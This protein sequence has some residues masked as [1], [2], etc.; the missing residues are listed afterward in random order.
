MSVSSIIDLLDSSDSS[1]V[2]SVH[3]GDESDT[4]AESDYLAPADIVTQVDDS[5]LI[6][7]VISGVDSWSDF[8]R[9][10][11]TKSALNDPYDPD[12][13]QRLEDTNKIGVFEDRDGKFRNNPAIN[14]NFVEM[15]E[16]DENM[17]M[18]M[19]ES[20]RETQD[21]WKK[22]FNKANVMPC[23]IHDYV[24]LTGDSDD[25]EDT[26]ED[27][28]EVAMSGLAEAFSKVSSLDAASVKVPKIKEK[29]KEWYELVPI[30]KLRYVIKKVQGN[31][32]E[33]SP[34]KCKKS[35]KSPKEAHKSSEDLGSVLQESQHETLCEKLLETPMCD[36]GECRFVFDDVKEEQ[37]HVRRCHKRLEKVD[38][39]EEDEL[40]TMQA[41][42]KIRL[43]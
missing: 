36:G 10:K 43:E 5:C 12:Y 34:K 38:E 16:S 25:D 37:E 3:S 14:E 19:T 41:S 8:F 32:E 7:S 2:E 4:S 1:D 31:P 21:F 30:Q 40:L 6:Q 28:F 39:E 17:T 22:S 11:K 13:I 24:D 29:S 35:H 20:E 18:G 9:R 26:G 42:K 33:E 27:K 23:V 15:V